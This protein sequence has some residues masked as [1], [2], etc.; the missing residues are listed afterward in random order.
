MDYKHRF[1]TIFSK[2]VIY[3]TRYNPIVLLK[4]VPICMYINLY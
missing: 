3:N 4:L 2:D 1:R